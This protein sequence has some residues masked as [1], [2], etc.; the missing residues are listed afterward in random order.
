MSAR[1]SARIP[2]GQ[3]GVANVG[4]QFRQG[5]PGGQPGVVN[6]GPRFHQGP[7]GPGGPVRPINAQIRPVP[8]RAQAA[9][10]PRAAAAVKCTGKQ[11]PKH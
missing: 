8:Q 9:V 3:P 7:A 4:P 1:N 6:A 10:A 11:C 5:I 2:G